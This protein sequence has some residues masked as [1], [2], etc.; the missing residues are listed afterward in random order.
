LLPSFPDQISIRLFW[1]LLFRCR[2]MPF[3]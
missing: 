3:P 2:S 1:I